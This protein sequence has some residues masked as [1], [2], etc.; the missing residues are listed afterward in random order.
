MKHSFLKV[1]EVESQIVEDEECLRPPLVSNIFKDGWQASSNLK[2][3]LPAIAVQVGI[4]CFL[5]IF[6][7]NN[8]RESRQR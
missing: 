1:G 3:D 5:Q 7:E 8:A 6:L 2:H 4:A